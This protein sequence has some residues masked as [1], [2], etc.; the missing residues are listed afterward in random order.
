MGTVADQQGA[1]QV[2]ERS[3]LTDVGAPVLVAAMRTPIGRLG[4]G[5]ARLGGVALGAEAIRGVLAGGHDLVPDHAMLGCVLQAAQ[6]QNPARQAAIL[7]GVPTTTSGITLNDVCLA[8]MSAVAMGALLVRAGQAGTVL[9]G[10]FDSMSRAPHAVVM[11]G[12]VALGDAPL[13]D[14]LVRDGLWCAFDDAGMGPQAEVTNA[15]LG[16]TRADQDAFALTSHH[17]AASARAAGLLAQEIVPVE[18]GGR[19]IVD[20]EGIRADSTAER[21]AGLRPAFRA[22]G[23]IT[24]GNASQLSDAGAAGL[25]TSAA[26]ARAAGLEPLAWVVDSAV[27]A[28]PDTS[29]HRKPAMAAR[30]VLERHGIAPRDV[31]RWEINEA[32]ASVVL[33]SMADLDIDHERVNVNGGAIALGHPLGASGFRLVMTLAREMARSGA[34][35]GVAAICGG[36]GQGEAVLLRRR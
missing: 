19:A 21:L 26:R 22:D 15:A 27:V 10:G 14:V 24:A 23:T 33:A 18:V 9:V 17:R 36:G 28:G 4:G 3:P 7:G 29:L 2:V 5:L 25:V 6:G 1:I 12:G 20:D 32:F 31:E 35:L 13:V 30:V 34:T 16:I 8:S 11:R